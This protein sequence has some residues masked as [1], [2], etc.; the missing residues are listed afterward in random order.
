MSRELR[1]RN[2]RLLGKITETGGRLEIR[3]A[4]GRLKGKY[5]PRTDKTYDANGRLA[6]TGNLLAALV[7][8]G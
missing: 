4:A 6:G 1:D 5:D 3:D 7:V 2:G 8:C